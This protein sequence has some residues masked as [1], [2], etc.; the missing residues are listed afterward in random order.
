M[1]CHFWVCHQLKLV[2]YSWI[3][4][5]Y[6]KCSFWWS[7]SVKSVSCF[8]LSKYK[9]CLAH[10]AGSSLQSRESP[11]LFF[12]TK[13]TTVSLEG[14]AWG[15]KKGLGY[16]NYGGKDFFFNLICWTG[17]GKILSA[18]KFPCER[19]ANKNCFNLPHTIFAYFVL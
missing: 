18:I 11:A 3:S 17:E 7:V 2:N 4:I 19:K 16:R 8:L 12:W 15:K 5:S 6:G 13:Y 9:Y 14:E 1:L 10:T